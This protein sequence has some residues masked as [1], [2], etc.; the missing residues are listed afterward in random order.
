LQAFS[1]M[2][3]EFSYRLDSDSDSETG[4]KKAKR[5]GG[6]ESYIMMRTLR[7]VQEDYRRVLP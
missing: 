1:A 2:P 4:S 3:M 5:W 7:G 6:Y